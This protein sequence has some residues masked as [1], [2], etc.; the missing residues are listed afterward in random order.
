MIKYCEDH[1]T[2][3]RQF[4]LS[5]LGETD[6]DPKDCNKTCDNCKKGQLYMPY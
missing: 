4:Q 3:R 6:F 2:C 1:A 5:Y